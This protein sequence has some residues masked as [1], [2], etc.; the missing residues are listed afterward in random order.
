MLSVQYSRVIQSKALL[1]S[2]S[3]GRKASSNG[4]LKR[5]ERMSRAP[6]TCQASREGLVGCATRSAGHM[7]S[8]CEEYMPAIAL[9]WSRVCIEMSL[10]KDRVDLDGP[11]SISQLSQA[12]SSSNVLVAL[13]WVGESTLSAQLEALCDL[14]PPEL[15]SDRLG[16]LQVGG[17][18]S[19]PG[20][21]PLKPTTSLLP[22]PSA[23]AVRRE[24]ALASGA[25]CLEASGSSS[26][27]GRAQA[28]AWSSAFVFAACI[29]RARASSLISRRSCASSWW[30][31]CANMFSNPS[32]FAPG[33]SELALGKVSVECFAVG[34]ACEAR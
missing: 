18:C 1:K 10:L 32:N 5:S 26:C 2:A 28:F 23:G 30:C 17:R 13:L 25:L 9:A 29:G 7:R 4:N 31:C 16:E 21:R 34:P 3:S 6:K 24:L 20:S 33:T 14:E 15:A 12:S 19:A 11:A 22:T 27:S 8:S